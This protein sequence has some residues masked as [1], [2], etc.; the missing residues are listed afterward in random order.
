MNKD[1]YWPSTPNTNLLYALSSP[2][3]CCWA[4][5]W[6]MSLRATIAGAREYAPRS[7]RGGCRSSALTAVYSPVLTGVMMP[8]GW[9]LT[10][11]GA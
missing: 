8:P 5:G 2:S 6:T 10:P 7:M 9:T 4:K 11:S 3:T 1:G